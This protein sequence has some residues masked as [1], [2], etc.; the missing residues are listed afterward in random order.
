MPVSVVARRHPIARN[1]LFTWQRLF[2]EGELP[3]MGIGEEAVPASDDRLL[4]QQ[5]RELQ[6]LLCKKTPEN[7]IL[8]EALD[9]VQPKTLVA[10]ALV[11][12]GRRAVKRLARALGLAIGASMR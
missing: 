11:G 8:R 12:S 1:Q 9:L 7:G 2:A 6:R 10:L 4:Q 5:V 3:A